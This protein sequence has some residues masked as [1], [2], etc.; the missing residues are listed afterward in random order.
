VLAQPAAVRAGGSGGRTATPADDRFERPRRRPTLGTVIFIGFVIFWAARLFGNVDLGGVTGP[1]ASA[2]ATPRATA[3][4]QVSFGPF[5]TPHAAPGGIAF[6]EEADSAGCDLEKRGTR[7]TTSVDVWWEAEMVHVIPADATVVYIEK[8]DNVEVDRQMVPPDPDVG[9]WSRFCGG[10]PTAGYQPGV[11]RIEIWNEGETELLSSGSF[12]RFDPAATSTP[13]PSRSPLP[14]VL[15]SQAG[16]VAFGTG[17]GAECTLS[18]VR[19]TFGTTEAVWWRAEL[20]KALP[21]GISVRLLTMQNGTIIDDV[22]APAAELGGPGF[23][24]AT[25][26][27]AGKGTAFYTVQVW[28]VDRT[29]ELASGVFERRP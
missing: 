28:S 10:G 14:T 27:T 11:Y 21:A 23:L 16:T 2:R 7:F 20:R 22:V 9:A 29:E 5:P 13:R 18:G 24:C 1:T 26:P 8:H 4:A 6:G 19:D 17:L 3:A 12:T 15:G 25:N